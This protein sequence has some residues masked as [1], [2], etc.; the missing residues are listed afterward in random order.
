MGIGI[1]VD[2]PVFGVCIW[3]RLTV[4]GGGREA[5][6][7]GE[8]SDKGDSATKDLAVSRF[9][10]LAHVI[11]NRLSPFDQWFRKSSTGNR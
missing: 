2:L 5:A 8:R 6:D 3:V 11:T 7:R 4:S 1:W 10:R 9:I